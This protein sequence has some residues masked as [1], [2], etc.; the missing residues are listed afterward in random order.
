MEP[1]NKGTSIALNQTAEPFVMLWFSATWCGPCKQI[2]PVIGM[3]E[4]GYAGT[5]KIVKV[6]TDQQSEIA[7]RF[8]IRSVPTLVLLDRETRLDTKV[9]AGSY[10]ELTQWLDSHI[11]LVT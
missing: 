3:I 8:G 4:Q 7:Q 11:N 9:G 2:E 1:N 6:D 10:V 5:V